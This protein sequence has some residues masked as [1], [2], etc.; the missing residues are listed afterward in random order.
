MSSDY[1]FM[2]IDVSLNNQEHAINALVTLLKDQVLYYSLCI[3][4]PV[5]YLSY[6]HGLLQTVC[7]W[8]YLTY[9]YI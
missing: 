8:N 2:N 5:I 4:D 9:S 1:I 7:I 6:G 3:E